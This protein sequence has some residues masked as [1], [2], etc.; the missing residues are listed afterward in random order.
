MI[1]HGNS[2]SYQVSSSPTSR[3]KVADL[4]IILIITL[5]QFQYIKIQ[6]GNN[7]RVC[8]VYSPEPGAE[9]YCLGLNF[10]RIGLS[11]NNS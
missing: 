2:P 11:D 10:G 8:G 6:P 9:V 1:C 5:D 7:Y 3:M 4:I